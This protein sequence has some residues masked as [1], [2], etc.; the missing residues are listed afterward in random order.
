MSRG[1]IAS[2]EIYPK[3]VTLP[4]S[5]NYPKISELSPGK[6]NTGGGKEVNVDACYAKLKS[7]NF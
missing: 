7:Q 4:H 5:K 2:S 1:R 6:K 3:G